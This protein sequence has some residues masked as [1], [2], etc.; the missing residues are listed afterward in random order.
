MTKKIV[1]SLV[2]PCMVLIGCG[3]DDKSSSESKSE[4]KSVDEVLKLSDVVYSAPQEIDFQNK[5]RM[6]LKKH[7]KMR[8]K[9]LKIRSLQ[10]KAETSSC[11]ISGTVDVEM[12]TDG[13]LVVLYHECI[14][15]NTKT[16]LSEYY[17]GKIQT[18]SKG[19]QISFYN[20]TERP[21]YE[22]Y[23]KM[24]TYY[25]DIKMS[26]SSV[27]GIED[28]KINGQLDVYEQDSVVERMNYSDF[29]I[30]SNSMNKSY[31]MAGDFADKMRCHS[32]EH[33]YQ[34]KNNDWLIEDSTDSKKISSGTLHVDELQY[35]YQQE[36]VEVTKKNQH[37]T[38][39]QQ[40][41]IDGHNENKAQTEC[42]VS[43]L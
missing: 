20:L 10:Q 2:L 17:D 27:E 33:K 1:V 3:S 18:N 32:E 11:D 30:K 31:Y 13:S 16:G 8:N 21:D 43:Y 4:T 25:K 29:T 22:N 34:T 7:K 19:N 36:N 9:L 23:P 6:R 26:Y 12:L 24:G 41:L 14:N 37:G 40:E 38:F 42:S 28:I 15:R 39:P 5:T 35:V